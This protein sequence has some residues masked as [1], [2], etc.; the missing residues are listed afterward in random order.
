MLVAIGVLLASLA[1]ACASKEVPCED[2][3]SAT[4]VQML[5]DGYAPGCVQAAEGTTL[6]VENAGEA[7]HT[8]TVSGTALEAKADPGASAPLAIT[9]VAPGTYVVLCT[10]HPDM[11]AALKVV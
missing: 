7:P 8:F 11:R 3:T 6:T 5:D 9:D 10:L 1:P 4:T 2:P